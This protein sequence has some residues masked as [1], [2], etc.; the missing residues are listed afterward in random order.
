MILSDL[1][2]EFETFE[3]PKDLD[4]DVA[5]L[6]GDIVAPGRVVARWLR[7]PARFDDKPVVQIA[8]NHEYSESVLD[9][10]EA[11]MRRQAKEHGVHFLDCDEVAIAGVRFLGCG[12]SEPCSQCPLLERGIDVVSI[13][14]GCRHWH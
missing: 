7:N 11:E 6:A 1:H 12:R 10:E 8:G 9:Q 14:L 4:Y 13:R 5:I 2:A 3:V